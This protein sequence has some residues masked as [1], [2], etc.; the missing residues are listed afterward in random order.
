MNIFFLDKNPKKCAIYHC[1]KHVV[2]MILETCQLLSTAHQVVSE[3]LPES[4]IKPGN[5]ENIMK[6]SYI[7]HP[8]NIWVRE[9]LE[10]YLWLT[11]LGWE[12]CKEYTYR[13]GKK[14]SR[15]D[16]IISLMDN[17]PLHIPHIGFTPPAQAM[18]ENCKKKDSVEAYREYYQQEKR[19]IASWKKR[20]IPFWYK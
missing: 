19:H 1:D 16:T 2:K 8:C 6:P 3:S 15:E 7:N 18:P 4:N 12:L 9:S 13:Y 5:V 20:S 10:N 11:K 17:W 14:H